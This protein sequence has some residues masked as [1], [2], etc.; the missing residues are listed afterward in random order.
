VEGAAH[1]RQSFLAWLINPHLPQPSE[2]STLESVLHITR[3][4]SHIL[5]ETDAFHTVDATIERSRDVLANARDVD[6][7]FKTREKGRY[8]MKTATEMGNEEGTAVSEV[9]FSV[10]LSLISCRAS[11]H[12]L[13]MHLEAR[14]PSKPIYPSAQKHVE[15]T[16]P[17]YLFHCPPI[18]T[19]LAVY[20]SSA[21]IEITQVTQAR[22]KACAVSKLS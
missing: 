21:W 11:P 14:R 17:P 20:L 8:Y 9:L 4:L 7:V 1:T 19:R 3:Q 22:R 5:Q 18:S 2:P 12:E 16:R 13:E 10:S 15:H 6:V